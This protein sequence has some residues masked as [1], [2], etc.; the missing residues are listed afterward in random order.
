MTPS[1]DSDVVDGCAPAVRRRFLLGPHGWVL[2]LLPCLALALAQVEPRVW[3]C[4]GLRPLA[5]AFADTI[6]VLAVGD[7]MRAGQDIFAPNPF[8]PWQRPHVYGPAWRAFG[9]LGLGVEDA[10]WVGA[11]CV[12]IFLLVAAAL[13]SPGRW[14]DVGLGAACLLS[15]PVMLAV[16]RGNN[17]LV[18]VSLL[19]LA[20]ALAA[21]ASRWTV[22]LAGAV[23][24]LATLLK[25]YPAAAVVLLLAIRPAA[26]GRRAF[27]AVGFALGLLGFAFAADFGHA[28]A[29]LPEPV[30]IYAYGLPVIGQ[31]WTA[32]ASG[33]WWLAIGGCAAAALFGPPL[34]RARRALWGS[35][36][37]AGPRQLAFMAGASAWLLCYASGSNFP[38][39]FVLLLLPASWWLAQPRNS[40]ERRQ[41]GA[42]LLVAWLHAPKHALAMWTLAQETPFARAALA[43]VVGFELGLVLTLSVALGVALGGILARSVRGPRGL[44]SA[45]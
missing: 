33:R 20:C 18:V 17:D 34:W 35:V 22:A 9:L 32:L 4:L 29:A 19:G 6:A 25:M 39:R 23:L 42:W 14:S 24:T 43:T 36:T 2:V 45:V 15:P 37:G 3:T 5:P 21:R 8:D 12:G 40:V 7:A 38:Y 31:S 26:L 30:T 10:G 1:S 41:F 11:L 44:A 28:L 27:V 16:E 13:L